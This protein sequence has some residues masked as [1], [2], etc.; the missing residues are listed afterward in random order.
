[1][2]FSFVIEDILAALGDRFKR[3]LAEPTEKDGNMF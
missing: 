2:I 3:E 1:M